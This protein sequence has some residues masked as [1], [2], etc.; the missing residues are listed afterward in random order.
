MKFKAF[1][2]FRTFREAKNNLEDVV[3]YLSVDLL[4]VLRELTNGLRKLSFNDNFNS[5]TVDVVIPATSEVAVRNELGEIPEGKLIIKTDNIDVIDST[6]T[7]N[8]VDF[9]YLENT[10]GTVANV[11]VVYFK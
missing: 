8:D 4:G 5:F 2:E 7:E 3:R 6:T 9:V 1:K 10:S 11:R